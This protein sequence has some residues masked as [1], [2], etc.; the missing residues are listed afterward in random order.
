[1]VGDTELIKIKSAIFRAQKGPCGHVVGD[2]ELLIKKTSEN[3]ENP[4][5]EQ[6]HTQGNIICKNTKRKSLM[7]HT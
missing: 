3:P 6:D 1:M 5:A 2:T 7:N 4:F